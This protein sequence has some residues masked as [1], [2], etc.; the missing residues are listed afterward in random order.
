MVCIPTPLST[1]SASDSCRAS[2]LVVPARRPNW[3][4]PTQSY[5]DPD[6]GQIAPATSRDS[7]PGNSLSLGTSYEH[8]RRFKYLYP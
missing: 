8:V 1:V 6:A 4:Y 7:V 3:H 5:R 2:D